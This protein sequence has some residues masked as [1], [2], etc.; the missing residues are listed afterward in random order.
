MVKMADSLRLFAFFVHSTPENS[1]ASQA[2]CIF[3]H[4]HDEIGRESQALRIPRPE[5]CGTPQAFC[6]ARMKMAESLR[7][8]APFGRS[9]PENW[10]TSQAICSVL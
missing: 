7:L 1:G 2:I 4:P 3:G 8:F 5:N 10:G 9:T 6:T